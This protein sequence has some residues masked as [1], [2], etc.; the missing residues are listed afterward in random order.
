MRAEARLH[1]VDVHIDIP[2]SWRNCGPRPGLGDTSIEK[3][4]ASHA[5]PILNGQVGET[6]DT[7]QM[8]ADQAGLAGESRRGVDT[9]VRHLRNNNDFLDYSQANGCGSF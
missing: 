7:L 8:Q 5:L 9:R 4:I 1:R 3:W 6:A 2:T